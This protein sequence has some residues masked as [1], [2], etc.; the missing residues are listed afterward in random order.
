MTGVGRQPRYGEVETSGAWR[1]EAACRTSHPDLFFPDATDDVNRK[2]A[3]RVCTGCPVRAECLREAL[4]NDEP[5]GIWGGYGPMTR[6][7]MAGKPVPPHG[8]EAR[9]QQG[10]CRCPACSETHNSGKRARA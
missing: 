3:V 2:R 8:T 5:H 4:R 9:Y 7:K 1:G 6:R 10:G